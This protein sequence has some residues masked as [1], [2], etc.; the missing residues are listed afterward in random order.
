M[1][2][3]DAEMDDMIARVRCWPDDV[4]ADPELSVLVRA[5]KEALRS[6]N[7]LAAVRMLLCRHPMSMALRPIVLVIFRAVDDRVRAAD[8]RLR[9]A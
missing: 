4:S 8:P 6:T 2:T 7:I 5:G 3:P 1:A 9:A